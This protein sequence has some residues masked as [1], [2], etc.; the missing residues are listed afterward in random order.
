MKFSDL[1]IGAKLASAFFAVLVLTAGIGGFAVVQ[2][3]KVNASTVDIA[4]N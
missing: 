3:G 4:S 2:L 1:K